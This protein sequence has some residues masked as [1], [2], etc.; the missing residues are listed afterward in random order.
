VRRILIFT[1]SEHDLE[2]ALESGDMERA[3]LMIVG[4]NA[5]VETDRRGEDGRHFAT[6]IPYGEMPVCFEAESPAL[7]MIGAWAHFLTTAR[8]S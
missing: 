6:F 3:A 5:M 4:E 8:R 2:A 7:A 1:D